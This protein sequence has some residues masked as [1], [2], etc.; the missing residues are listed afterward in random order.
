MLQGLLVVAGWTSGALTTLANHCGMQGSLQASVREMLQL[1]GFFR[2]LR[3]WIRRYP[4]MCFCTSPSFLV[5]FR[6]RRQLLLLYPNG[7]FATSSLYA[8]SSVFRGWNV[9]GCSRVCVQHTS[10][11]RAGVEAEC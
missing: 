1:L 9:F 3:K 6:L 11:R 7:R 8:D 4:C 2:M 5:P 10:L